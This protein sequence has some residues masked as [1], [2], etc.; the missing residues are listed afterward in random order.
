MFPSGSEHDSGR[1]LSAAAARLHG[2][3]LDVRDRGGSSLLS[4]PRMTPPARP[5]QPPQPGALL[6]APLYAPHHPGEENNAGARGG[7]GIVRCATSSHTWSCSATC[8][9]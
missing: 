4:P 6:L 8:W 5:P 9:T 1:W 3:S 7:G 2:V